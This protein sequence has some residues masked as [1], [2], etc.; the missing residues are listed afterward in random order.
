MLFSIPPIITCAIRGIKVIHNVY[1]GDFVVQTLTSQ[2]DSI[3]HTPSSYLPSKK[4]WISSHVRPYL[5]DPLWNQHIEPPLKRCWAPSKERIVLSYHIFSSKCPRQVAS[6]FTSCWFQPNWKICSSNWIVSPNFRAENY[7]K[8]FETT[9]P[10]NGFLPTNLDIL[11]R[12]CGVPIWVRIFPA[13]FKW[14]M[15]VPWRVSLTGSNFFHQPEAFFSSQAR[16]DAAPWSSAEQVGKQTQWPV[17]GNQK[18]S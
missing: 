5:I 14:D 10:V 11:Y 13:T 8:T 17:D 4:R 16:A 15:L 6:L 18:S 9:T 1:L 12:I 3:S 2:F 7:H